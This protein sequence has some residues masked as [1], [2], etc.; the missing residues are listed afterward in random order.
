MCGSSQKGKQGRTLVRKSALAASAPASGHTENGAQAAWQKPPCARVV[1]KATGEHQST[2]TAS[3]K[4]AHRPQVLRARRSQHVASA[5]CIKTTAD[6]RCTRN[7]MT[8][9]PLWSCA[10]AAPGAS[11]GCDG[12]AGAPMAQGTLPAMERKCRI[13]RGGVQQLL[14][15]QRR[16]KPPLLELQIAA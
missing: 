6:R 3:W 9:S 5:D 1:W 2:T 7:R 16:P 4:A 8:F 15:P 14:R 10:E 12:Q 13:N 11:A